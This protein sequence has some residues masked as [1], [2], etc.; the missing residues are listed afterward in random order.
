MMGGSGYIECSTVVLLDNPIAV[1]SA[2]IA[3]VVEFCCSM[4]AAAAAPAS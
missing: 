4:A 1:A 2:S 3:Y